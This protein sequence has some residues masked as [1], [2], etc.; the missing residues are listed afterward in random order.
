MKQGFSQAGQKTRLW[1]LSF[2]FLGVIE[3]NYFI[4]LKTILLQYDK[5]RAVLLVG[6]PT[7]VNSGSCADFLCAPRP[8]LECYL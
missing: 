6:V 5:S 4:K 7:E 3:Y 8:S 1:F 2:E